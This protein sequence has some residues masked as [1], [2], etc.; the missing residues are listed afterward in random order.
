MTP[1]MWNAED[2]ALEEPDSSI[3]ELG[4]T[5]RYGVTGW[6]ASHPEPLALALAQEQPEVQA[7]VVDEQWSE[8]DDADALSGRLVANLAI[9]DDDYALVVEDVQDYAPEELAMH[10]VVT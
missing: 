9:G 5:W 10:L 3:E 2:G 8:I 7:P 6:E 4:S 1:W